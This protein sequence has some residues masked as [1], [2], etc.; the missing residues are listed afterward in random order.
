MNPTKISEPYLNDVCD[1][2]EKIITEETAKLNKLDL[3]KISIGTKYGKK[4]SNKFANLLCPK[5]KL[6][7]INRMIG[8][9]INVK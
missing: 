2:C 4:L 7:V 1:S 6:K 5:C 8:R 3:L 9:T